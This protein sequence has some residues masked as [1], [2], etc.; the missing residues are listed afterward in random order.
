MWVVGGS[1]QEPAGFVDRM[2]QMMI[3]LVGVICFF[4][5]NFNF[6]R[7]SLECSGSILA[8]FNLHLPG[9][10]DSRA[11]ACRVAQTTEM[12]FHRVSQDGLDILTLQSLTLLPR[13]ECSGVFSAHCNFCLPSSSDSPASAS[14]VA[15]ISGDLPASASKSAGITGVSH[16]TQPPYCYFKEL[17]KKWDD[18]CMC[19]PFSLCC[20][21]SQSSSKALQVTGTPPRA[22]WLPPFAPQPHCPHS[23]GTVPWRQRSAVV[24][25]GVDPGG[26]VHASLCH[27]PASGPS[28]AS[29][30]WASSSP[31]VEGVNR[32]CAM[33][34]RHVG[35]TGLKLLT[36]GDL[37]ASASHNAGITGMSPHDWPA[38]PFFGPALRP[39]VSAGLFSR[40]RSA[41]ASCQIP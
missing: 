25:S 36:S 19:A 23:A 7:Q 17:Q 27:S 38:L 33:G 37:P 5:F 20:S 12:E 40:P 18:K 16:C 8:H 31:S 3:I 11:S 14:R 30:L 28:A 39:Q 13:L 24:G 2:G 26:L 34:F 21:Q 15:G 6:L 10:S 35:Q 29:P 4:F 32:P 1:S 41:V 9:S 22:P